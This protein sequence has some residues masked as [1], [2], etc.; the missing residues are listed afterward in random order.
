MQASAALYGDPRNIFFYRT[1][2]EGTL[3]G[4]AGQTGR[5]IFSSGG[6]TE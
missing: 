4:K 3:T 6:L 1:F 5:L 2:I